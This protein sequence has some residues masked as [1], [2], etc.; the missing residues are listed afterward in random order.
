[1]NP[2]EYLANTY[3]E[4]KRILIISKKPTSEEYFSLLKIS[5]LGI[6]VIG[7]I[8]FLVQFLAAIIV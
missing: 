3:N 8:G 1:M 2:R 5:A 4:Y 6:G 7:L